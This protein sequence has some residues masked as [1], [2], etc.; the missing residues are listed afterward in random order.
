MDKTGGH[1][2]NLNQTEREIL[3]NISHMWNPKKKKQTHKNSSMVVTRG[4]G[5]EKWGEFDKVIINI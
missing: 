4:W 1:K 5:W 3:P 2:A